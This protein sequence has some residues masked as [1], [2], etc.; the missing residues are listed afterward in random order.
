MSHTQ[1]TKILMDLK[2]KD[3]ILAEELTEKKKNEAI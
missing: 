2:D 1:L 3:I